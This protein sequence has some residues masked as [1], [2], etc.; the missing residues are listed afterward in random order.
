MKTQ[1]LFVKK[2]R[3]PNDGWDSYYITADEVRSVLDAGKIPE[4][5]LAE[6]LSGPKVAVLMAVEKHPDRE[7]ADYYVPEFYVEA[8]TRYGAQPV[9]V[10]F[11]KTTE[12]LENLNPRALMLIGGDF[13]FPDN[14]AEEPLAHGG[15]LRR[16]QAYEAVVN[17]ARKHRWPLLGIC[18]GEQVIA[19]MHGAKLK[20]VA[21][22]RQ[23]LD[24]PCHAVNIAP[25]SLLHR[26]TGETRAEINSHHY[27][28]VSAQNLGDCLAAAT[29]DDGTVEAVELKH[30]WHYFVLGLQW[31]AERFVRRN[32]PVTA[33]IFEA[34]VKA[35]RGIVMINEEAEEFTDADM[36][37]ISDPHFII[38]MIYAHRNNLIS[39]DVYNPIGIGNRAFVRRA[40]WERLQK[41]IPWLEEH[42]LRMKICDAYRSPEAH[43]AMKTAIHEE[44]PGMFASRPVISKHCHGTAIDVVLT[45]TDGNELSYPT[46]I[47][48]YTPE[49]AA[50]IQAGNTAEYYE[51]C[52]QGR[53]DYQNPAMSA[54]IANRD[55][56]RALMEDIGLQSY[57]GE[58]WHYE[59]PD[60]F[61]FTFPLIN[62]Q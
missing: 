45:D 46:K 12:Q 36:V 22:H 14:W 55:Q 24:E 52:K 60:E 58:W 31:H 18:A 1:K 35:A 43:M 7:E 57:M 13:K 50:Q 10:G 56:L 5:C 38:D 42:N 44:G 20:Q 48:C 37:E 53:H 28:A 9:F 51:Y 21:Q 49:F 11:D 27:D 2:S 25:G 4:I 62:W 19:G 29:A 15:S 39:A 33:K 61:N 17:Y 23:T 16:E 41:A 40:L 3:Y 8:L 34:F 54:E 26:I 6:E 32:D 47:D 59:M 30:P